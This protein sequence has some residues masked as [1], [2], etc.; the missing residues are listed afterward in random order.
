MAY[1]VALACITSDHRTITPNTLSIMSGI[2]PTSVTLPED[3]IAMISEELFKSKSFRTLLS[4]SRV[5]KQFYCS[6]LLHPKRHLI[7]RDKTEW[8][9]LLDGLAPAQSATRRYQKSQITVAR[10]K[11]RALSRYRIVS[12]GCF[13]DTRTLNRIIDLRNRLGVN[14]LLPQAQFVQFTSAAILSIPKNPVPKRF[15]KFLSRVSNFAALAQP[16]ACGLTIPGTSL[17]HPE[18]V[19]NVV[20]EGWLSL[21]EILLSGP[22]RHHWTLSIVLRPICRSNPADMAR[23]GSSSQ[24][25]EYPVERRISVDEYG[26]KASLFYL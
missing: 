12:I 6:T 24:E 1:L 21:G 19:M 26:T 14:S 3:V 10:R 20:L 25:L 2:P 7:L 18:I 9:N 11:L 23:E 16:S 17:S 22:G 4:L 15:N 5:S 8:R 13:P